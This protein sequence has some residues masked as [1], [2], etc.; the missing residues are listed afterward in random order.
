M[1]SE[2][3]RIGIDVGG[4]KIA[5][6]LFDAAGTL[7]E[8]RRRATQNDAS[9][10]AFAD[11]V[12]A[13][14]RSL[15]AAHGLAA[16]QMEGVALC[17]PSSVDSA[18]GVVV[19]TPTIPALRNFD[20]RGVFAPRLPGMRLVVDNDTNA[21]A[22]AEHRHGA[23]RGH[24][25]MLFTTLGTGIGSGLILGGRL[26][27]GAFGGAGESGHMIIEPGETACFCG[28]GNPGCFMGMASGGCVAKRIRADAAR[29]EAASIAALAGRPEDITAVTLK[30]AFDA[31]DA[32]AQRTVQRMGRYIG[33]YLFNCFCLLNCDCYILGGGLV[34]YGPALLDIVRSTFTQYSASMRAPDDGIVILPA[35]TGDDMG[36]IGAAE[37]LRC[38][39]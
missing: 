25:H 2:G 32:Y 29:G 35:Q 7:V 34:H 3:Y 17:F 11:I 26:Y 21:A 15:M 27:R 5:Y 24:D 13:E 38:E 37:L 36:I 8:K 9:Q 23:G 19:F 22:L 18:R 28:C 39:S 33:L 30:Q 14:V 20:A 31:G 6:G 1:T 4:T 12:A 16:A 10:E